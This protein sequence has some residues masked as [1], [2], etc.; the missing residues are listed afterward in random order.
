MIT[1]HDFDEIETGDTIGYLKTS[2]EYAA[3]ESA[4]AVVT[5]RSPTLL[6]PTI[7]AAS[8]E[9]EERV[10]REALFARAIDKFEPLIHLYNE[11]GRRIHMDKKCTLQHS[12]SIKIDHVKHFASIKRFTDTLH[13]RMVVEGYFYVES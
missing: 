10:S 5:E 8:R 13:N 4:R 12:E 9:Y 6:Q 1:I 3:E 11:N 7:S 2:A